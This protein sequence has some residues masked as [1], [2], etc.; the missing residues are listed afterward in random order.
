MAPRDAHGAEV[1]APSSF[2]KVGALQEQ[3]LEAGLPAFVCLSQFGKVF[4]WKY[5]CEIWVT[6][7]KL[8]S[9]EF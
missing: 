2:Y 8:L 7:V 4:K 1:R 9:M 3:T 5:S 6:A